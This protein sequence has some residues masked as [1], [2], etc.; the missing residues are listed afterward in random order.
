M[1][2]FLHFEIQI[3]TKPMI[4]PRNRPI[5]A[6]IAAGKS[7]CMKSELLISG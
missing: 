2:Q 3:A 1:T 6:Q 7:N 4:N 5:K